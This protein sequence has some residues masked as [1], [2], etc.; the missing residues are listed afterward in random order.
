MHTPLAYSSA[1]ILY[2]LVAEGSYVAVEN[3]MHLLIQQIG[4]SVTIVTFGIILFVLT[5]DHVSTEG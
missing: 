3:V 2:N 4:F 1:F 5:S